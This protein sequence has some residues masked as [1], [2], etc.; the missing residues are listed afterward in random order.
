DERERERVAQRPLEHRA[1][2]HVLEILEADEREL[3]AARRRVRE[4]QKHGEQEGHRHQQDDVQERRG[5]HDDAEQPLGAPDTPASPRGRHGHG[6]PGGPI[7]YLSLPP[8]PTIFFARHLSK[9]WRAR[10]LASSIESREASTSATR[11]SLATSW[12]FENFHTT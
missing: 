2:H 8:P 11:N 6:Q 10:V 4:R 12:F 1:R 5:Q 7:H 9:I 3:Q